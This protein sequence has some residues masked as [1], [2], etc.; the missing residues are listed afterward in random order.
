MS[1]QAAL[2]L[3]AAALVGAQAPP[4]AEKCDAGRRC[5]VDGDGDVNVRDLLLTLSAFG[6]TT[7]EKLASGDVNRDGVCNVRDILDVLS[8]FNIDLSQCAAAGSSS[9]SG[10]APPAPAPAADAGE[11]CT[12]AC[13]TGMNPGFA[14]GRVF[15][16]GNNDDGRL[17][18]GDNED[19]NSPV[20]IVAAGS[21]NV[22][23][24][25]GGHASYFLKAD[26]RVFA[27]GMNDQGQLGDGTTDGRS[28]PEEV[29][30]ISGT[31]VQ[32]GRGWYSVML[33]L[34]ADG[35]VVGWGE[36]PNGEVSPV[37]LSHLTS[38]SDADR[39]C[40]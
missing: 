40:Q 32:M 30:G 11:V 8:A 36:N 4:T 16:V 23:I 24:S 25:A 38:L 10:T 5:D 9:G 6:G 21:D 28:V 20:E 3:L 19:R 12:R 15:G 17:G 18:L 39:R 22:A 31:V 2:L 29:T 7:P 34:M 37:C 14:G 26:G 27:T 1:P 35:S 33:L 13:I